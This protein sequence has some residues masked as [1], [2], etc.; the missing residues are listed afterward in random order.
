M[1]F[2]GIG[3]YDLSSLFT[4]Y[5]AN[6]KKAL[7]ESP[8]P[9]HH[10]VRVLDLLVDRE[11][12]EVL[13]KWKSAQGLLHKVNTRLAGLERKG[14]VQN[15]HILAFEPGAYDDW[16]TEEIIDPDAFMRIHVLLNPSPN[17]RLYSSEEM[18]APAP[19]WG[20]AVDHQG[21]VSAANFNG[22]NTAHELVL[23]LALDVGG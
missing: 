8:A 2:T 19:W 4:S 5:I 12:T 14:D 17:F 10:K 1:R 3:Y 20:V 22:P 16:H 7:V 11:Q 13:Q 18:S 21:P 6:Q 15:A 9:H 23:E